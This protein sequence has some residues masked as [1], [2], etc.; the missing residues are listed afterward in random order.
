MADLE[1]KDLLLVIEQTA[2][3]VKLLQLDDVWTSMAVG[4]PSLGLP[5]LK[6][7]VSETKSLIYRVSERA[8]A[9]FAIAEKH[10][11]ALAKTTRD[12]LSSGLLSESDRTDLIW[13][14]ARLGSDSVIEV[15]RD[16]MQSLDNPGSE[17]RHL[18]EQLRQII[19]GQSANGDLSKEFRCNLSLTLIGG[20]ILALPSSAAAGLGAMA[21]V[22]GTAVVAGMFLTGGVGGIALLVAGLLVARRNKC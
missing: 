1:T 13:I 17:V 5:N 18:D 12:L 22:G 16:A 19:E 6:T 3:C 9:V 7:L 8:P 10:S 15:L 14:L 21:V 11:D 20:S 2:D 4:G